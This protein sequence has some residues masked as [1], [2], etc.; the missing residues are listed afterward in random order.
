[1]V[2]FNWLTRKKKTC[3]PSK[4]PQKAPDSTVKKKPLRGVGTQNPFSFQW[5]KTKN[6]TQIKLKK[7]IWDRKR[8]SNR[9][10]SL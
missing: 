2:S 10:G 4:V 7:K 1:M 8:F 9:K 6:Q 3:A 5:S